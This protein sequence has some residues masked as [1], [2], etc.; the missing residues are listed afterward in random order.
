MNSLIEAVA[1]A[2]NSVGKI[3]SGLNIDV[4]DWVPIIGGKKLS[5]NFPKWTPGKFPYL[6]QGGI[7]KRGQVGILEGNGA[8]AVI[9]LERNRQWISKVSEEMARSS[10]NYSGGINEEM[11]ANAVAEGVAMALMNNIDNLS[12]NNQQPMYITLALENDEAIARA[13]I[14]GQQSIDYRMNPTPQH[15]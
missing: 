4:P 8:E 7:L 9:P 2:V 6:E 5:F 3:L 12:S 10:Y 14:R 11:L 13:A 15:G 1:F